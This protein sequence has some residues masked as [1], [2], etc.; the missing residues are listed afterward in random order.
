[1]NILYPVFAM[2][3]LTFFVWLRMYYV[4]FSVMRK[5]DLTTADMQPT[6]RNLP[7]AIIFSGDNFRNLCELP[8]L[9]YTVSLIILVL[10]LTDSVFLVCAWAFVIFRILHS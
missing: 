10:K 9:F 2:V 5:F 1:M 6:N 8:I 4:R 3:L 7:A